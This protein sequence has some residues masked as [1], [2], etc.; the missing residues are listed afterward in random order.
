MARSGLISKNLFTMQN[1]NTDYLAGKES[2]HFEEND[3]L[4]D[5]E[6]WFAEYMSEDGNELCEKSKV[7]EVVQS[8]VLA[9]ES[10]ER[11]IREWIASSQVC[12]GFCAGC[13]DLL[14]DWPKLTDV[15]SSEIDA[16]FKGSWK[17]TIGRP[18]QT[19]KLEASARSGCR[20]CSLLMQTL[21]DAQVLETY[22]KIEARMDRQ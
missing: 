4:D 10:T 16:K 22:R 12:R 15:L 17:Y 8:D 9:A 21:K 13:Q 2:P 7:V 3:E 20:F 5:L 19:F 14:D 18:C 6:Q 11:R 1:I